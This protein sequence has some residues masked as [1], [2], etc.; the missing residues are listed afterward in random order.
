MY[1]LRSGCD[2][3]YGSKDLARCAA[4]SYSALYSGSAVSGRRTGGGLAVEVGEDEEAA[5]DDYDIGDRD[6]DGGHGGRAGE[7][8]GDV[9][10]G[11]AGG[12]LARPSCVWSCLDRRALWMGLLIC[13]C[14]CEAGRRGRVHN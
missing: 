7:V 8:D 5:K 9:F 14:H 11:C 13:T 3:K 1:A 12:L 6:E 10:I 4:R 2:G